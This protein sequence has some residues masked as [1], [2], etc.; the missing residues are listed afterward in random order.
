VQNYLRGIIMFLKSLI[1]V[2]CLLMCTAGAGAQSLQ[3]ALNSKGYTIDVALDEIPGEVFFQKQSSNAAIVFQ[4]SS[5]YLIEAIGWYTAVD[6]GQWLIG[7]TSTGLPMAAF[8][9]DID[10]IFGVKFHPN[11]TGTGFIYG[12][13]YS[14]PW[15]NSDG[16]DHVRVFPTKVGN[17]LVPFSYLLC[18]E[19]WV[20]GDYQ[21]LIVRIDWVEAVQ[22]SGQPIVPSD[23]LNLTQWKTS[24]GGN[25]HWYCIMPVRQ[26]WQQ[27]RNQ[28]ASMER[29]GQPGYLA[30][31]TS[32]A[33]SDF[34]LD[35]I[36]S[37]VQN[38]SNLCQFYMGGFWN[39]AIW[40]WYTGEDFDY[41]HWTSGEPNNIGTETVVTTWGSFSPNRPE[42]YWNNSIPTAQLWSIMEW[43][44][45]SA[46]PPSEYAI[47]GAVDGPSCPLEGVRVSLLSS[48][49]VLLAVQFTGADGS[50]AFDGLSGG[51]YLVSLEVP[52]G[53]VPVTEPSRSVSLMG[54]PVEVDFELGK[55]QPGTLAN[56]W[57]WKVY[58]DD[59]R[60]GGPRT[61]QFTVGDVNAWGQVIY[62]HFQNRSDGNAIQIGGITSAGD[63]AHALTFA[64]ICYT[65][66]DQDQSSYESMV[67]YNMLGNLLNIV[68]NRMHQT[69]VVTV[70]GATA[71][72]AITYFARVYEE[73]AGWLPG[74]FG[75]RNKLIQAYQSL[76][77][78]TMGKVLPAGVVP[79]S[80]PNVMFK[81]VDGET[82]SQ[83]PNGW[84]LAQNYPNPFNP[85]TEIQFALPEASD[86]RLT[87]YN[88]LGQTVATLVNG[89]VEAGDHTVTW[90]GSA[91]ASGVYL[92]RLEAG[93]YSEAKK[94]LLLK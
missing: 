76:R 78:M 21:D 13:F 79:L 26:T 44:G 23:P 5:Q 92:Y 66:L 71:S 54:A 81:S 90:D 88:V 29:D 3:Q 9:P 34:I 32:Q 1:S 43:G 11:Y 22:G 49:S 68:S 45:T 87:V 63:P 12:I 84:S 62:D 86:V 31:V 40:Y 83:L 55:T 27:S 73:N 82:A 8:L 64:D 75:K 38:P 2:V 48:A 14:E 58:L 51:D 52:F 65:M 72:Q 17:Q 7:G 46:L 56:V 77:D 60:A 19:D 18:W 94:M 41:T 28:A 80:I 91:A 16:E 50:Y 93:T 15:R 6:T 61:D 53:F 67:K 59:L 37:G 42:G 10:T 36:I 20:D 33:E 24:D 35:H 57:W 25:D 39:D 47:T 30:T 4:E 69:R 74:E 85:A 89:H 70:D